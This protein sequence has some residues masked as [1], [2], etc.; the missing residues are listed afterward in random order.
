MVGERMEDIVIFWPCPAACEVLALQPGI[1]PHLLQWEHRV[2]TSGLPAK[3][4]RGCKGDMVR[5]WITA[6]TLG[7]ILH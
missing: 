5:L 1:K 4:Q 7:V 6:P 2:L 3:S